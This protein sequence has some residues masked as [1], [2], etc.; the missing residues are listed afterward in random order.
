M[1]FNPTLAIGVMILYMA[2]VLGV[3]LYAAKGSAT[4]DLEG[5]LLADRKMHWFTG[6]F[7]F[8]AS[9]ISALAFMGLVAFYYQFGIAAFIAIAGLGLI[10]ITSGMLLFL[11]PRIWKIGRKY[12][13]MTPSDTL[14]EYYDSPVYGYLVAI[15]LILAMVPYLEIQFKGVGIAFLIGTGGLVPIAYGSAII[16]IVIAI[17]TW[18][19][20]M[21]SVAWVDTMQGVM[22]LAGTFIGGL[23]ILFTAVGGFVP[24][25]ETILGSGGQ[26]GMLEIPGQA[27]VFDWVYILTF[28]IPV[29][30]GWVFSPHIWIRLHYFEDGRALF[31][32][33]WVWALIIWLTQVGGWAVVLTGIVIATDVPP[34]QFVLRMH[35]EFFPTV[36]FAFIASAALAAMM[37]TASSIVHGIGS[38]VSRDLVGHIKPEWED[39]QVLIARITIM[40]T[41]FAA[42]LVSL[43]DVALLLES[44]AAAASLSCALVMPQVIAA[45]YGWQWPTKQGALAASFLGPVV[46]LALLLVPQLTSPLGFY[47]GAWG[48]I[49][50][51]VVFGLV[52]LVTST[53]P[54]DSMIRSWQSAL[55]EPI[56][57]LDRD[58][59][60]TSVE[61]GA[62]DD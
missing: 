53:H 41:I 46:F 37:S 12:G 29:F 11:G 52:S 33:P 10:I 57:N 48:L 6:F 39:K 14:R 59:R 25:Y 16:A 15:G 24:A 43:A 32:L 34:D 42:F 22:L 47:A 40:I 45:V 26:S 58:F 31:H 44:G 7:S 18:A 19:G 38:V 9:M 50:N 4:G 3:G 28:S 21:K 20:G 60:D 5:F 55:R 23:A 56:T 27:G 35:R 36:V 8:A 13:H 51:V 1:A 61:T 54:D 49:T 2:V 17:Y 30:A 62:D